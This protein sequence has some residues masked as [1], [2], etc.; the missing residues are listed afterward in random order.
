[1]KTKTQL[2][3][4]AMLLHFLSFGQSNTSTTQFLKYDSLVVVENQ[5]VIYFGHSYWVKKNSPDSLI[6]K[7]TNVDLNF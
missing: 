6:R 3:F 4:L 1:M 5:S 2:L 7:Y